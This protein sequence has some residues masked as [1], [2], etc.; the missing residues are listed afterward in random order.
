MQGNNKLKLFSFF[1]FRFCNCKLLVLL[2]DLKIVNVFGYID[3][4]KL[5]GSSYDLVL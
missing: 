1:L 3:F 5:I 2:L 4:V